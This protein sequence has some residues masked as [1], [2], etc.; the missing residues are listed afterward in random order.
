M[1]T[2]INKSHKITKDLTLNKMAYKL[3]KLQKSSP[4]ALK[5]QGL[6]GTNSSY[7]R[8]QFDIL[9]VQYEDKPE[10]AIPAINGF[11]HLRWR[12]QTVLTCHYRIHCP[13]RWMAIDGPFGA[14]YG[15]SKNLRQNSTK[16]PMYFISTN[17][18][19]TDAF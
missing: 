8:I 11:N 15:S 2:N 14:N 4:K 7:K 1:F 17:H 19:Q 9:R 10:L 12:V 3:S 18:N 13:L 6:L 5:A 16:N